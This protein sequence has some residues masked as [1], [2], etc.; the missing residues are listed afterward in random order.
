MSIENWY[1]CTKL[2]VKKE[3]LDVFLHLL[4]IGLQNLNMLMILSCVQFIVMMI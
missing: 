2:I 4:F 3:Q 1:D